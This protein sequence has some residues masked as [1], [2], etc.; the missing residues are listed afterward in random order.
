MPPPKIFVIILQFNN[1]QD[2]I[3]CLNSVLKVLRPNF[4][5]IVVDNASDSEHTDS[6]RRYALSQSEIKL[7]KNINNLGY[8]GGNNIGI[9]YALE[10]GADYVLILNN[11][12]SV[13]PDILEKMVQLAEADHR[14]G[15]VGPLIKEGDKIFAGGKIKWLKSELEHLEYGVNKKPDYIPGSCMLIKKDV[16]EKIGLFDEKY[17]LYF[18]DADYSIRARKAKYKLAITSNT[19][20]HHGGSSST[21]KL[22]NPQLLYYHYRNALYFNLKNG[23]WYIKIL[24]WPWSLMIALKQIFKILLRIHPEHSRSILKGVMDFYKLY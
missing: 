9:K 3:S 20:I 19:T 7:L 22:G 15:I 5:I 13:E 18:E 11:D 21:K 2:T 10:N 4:E 14:I 1:S 6:I 12:T 17:Y 23:A 16:I 8:S 24:V